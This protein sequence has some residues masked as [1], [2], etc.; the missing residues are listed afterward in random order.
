MKGLWIALV[1]GVG[2]LLG[3][4]FINSNNQEAENPRIGTMFDEL[5]P[6]H[7]AIGQ[8][9]EPYNSNPPTSGAHYGQ[10]AEWGTYEEQLPDEQVVHNLEHGGIVISYRPDISEDQLNSLRQ[11]FERLP[12]SRLFNNQKAI[13]MPRAENESLVALTAWQYLLELNEVD[14]AQILAF[15]ESHVDKGPEQVP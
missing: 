3:L 7:I 12:N 15:Y 8:E 11:I 4:F 14:E 1:V 6:L 9:H 13:L 2:I 10:P 5:E